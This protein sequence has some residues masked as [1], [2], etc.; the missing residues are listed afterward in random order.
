MVWHSS[1]DRNKDRN[2]R[3]Y[4]LIQQRHRRGRVNQVGQWLNQLLAQSK[5]QFVNA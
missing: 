2:H 3:I 4:T 1:G 5:Y